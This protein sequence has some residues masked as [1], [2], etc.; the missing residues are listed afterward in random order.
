MKS[1]RAQAHDG[2]STASYKAS[3]ARQA[4]R[5]KLPS[6]SQSRDAKTARFRSLPDRSGALPPIVTWKACPLAIARQPVLSSLTLR[7]DD[8]DRIALLGVNSS[9]K[10]TFAKLSPALQPGAG[11]IVRLKTEDRPLRAASAECSGMVGL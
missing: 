11:S 10:S 8:D 4:R 6:C 3:K 7:L 5:G 2:A 9:S 1:R